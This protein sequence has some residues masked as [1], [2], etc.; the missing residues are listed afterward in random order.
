[1]YLKF[2]VMAMAD[3]EARNILDRQAIAR[4]K[5]TDKSPVVR[6]YG[7]G[8]EGESNPR[9]PEMG[10][11]NVR[12]VFS[13]PVIERIAANLAIDTPVYL[14][15]YTND[16][17]EAGRV[18]VGQVVGVSTKIIGGKMNVLAAVYVNP[19]HRNSKLDVASI[20]A[21]TESVYN[22]QTNT[23]IVLDI[24]D[25]R[26]VALGNSEIDNP[27]FN[28]ARLKA[29]IAAFA[30]DTN[31]QKENKKMGLDDL[32]PGMVRQYIKANNLSVGE[33]FSR[34]EIS[35]DTVIASILS[36]MTAPL[37]K[38]VA[39]L[40]TEKTRVVTEYET[41]V[42]GYSSEL[43]RTKVAA[44]LPEIAKQRQ[45]TDKQVAYINSEI[46][47]ANFNVDKLDEDLTKFVDSSV[48]KFNNLAKT[49]GIDIG[50]ATNNNENGNSG[51]K[52]AI[53]PVGN[54]GANPD[55]AAVPP[56]LLALFPNNKG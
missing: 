31:S 54:S 40:E 45:L 32:T 46:G 20:E 3:S 8:E 43:A 48:D 53:P 44:K 4:I 41:K 37:N 26:A 29:Q 18:M 39:E 9:V 47:S 5:K 13:R 6:I 19:E 14:G 52:P 36:D 17:D 50:T 21:Y 56:D 34:D 51:T 16:P 27:A 22:P 25:I 10:N 7:V 24:S 15:H 11:V 42:K 30:V 2:N 55:L 1:M 23:A 33:L 49:L 38:K 28:N 12:M 35:K